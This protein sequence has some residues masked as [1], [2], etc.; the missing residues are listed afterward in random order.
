MKH[1]TQHLN[2]VLPP[3][4]RHQ[5]PALVVA[6]NSTIATLAFLFASVALIQYVDIAVVT[7]FSQMEYTLWHEGLRILALYINPYTIFIATA[8]IIGLQIMTLRRNKKRIETDRTVILLSAVLVSLIFTTLLKFSLGRARPEIWFGEGYTG[9]FGFQTGRSFHSLPSGHATAVTAMCIAV[10]QLRHETAYRL[11][12][13][14]LTLL[15]LSSRLFLGE[16][17]PADVLAGIWLGSIV[18]Y[19]AQLFAHLAKDRL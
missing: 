6:R 13:L 11:L 15:I 5:N 18:M 14:T 7:Y 17:F 3:P 1:Q 4:S 10:F 9:F 16:H 12:A 2:P 8:G 19:W